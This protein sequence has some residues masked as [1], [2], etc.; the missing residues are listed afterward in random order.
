[1]EYKITNCLLLIV[2][3]RLKIDCQAAGVGPPRAVPLWHSQNESTLGTP[4]KRLST[5]TCR[6]THRRTNA[7]AERRSR[8]GAFFSARI[9]LPM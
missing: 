5:D 2:D 4:E 8:I 3:Q 1:M 7:T 9:R 6:H